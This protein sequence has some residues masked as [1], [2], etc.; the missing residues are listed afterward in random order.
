MRPIV[1]RI[2]YK[3]GHNLGVFQKLFFVR[4]VARN[5]TFVNAAKT[6]CT[7]FV[8]VARKPQFPYV[9]KLLV[10][11]NITFVEMT[12]IVDYGKMRNFAVNFARR[13]PRK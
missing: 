11:F 13:I 10:V 9:G 7:P 6:H 1:K 4:A 3:F 12:V 5:I 2:A 8:M